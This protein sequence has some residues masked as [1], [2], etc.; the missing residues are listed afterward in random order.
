MD[1]R[2]HGVFDSR[3]DSPM[4][5]LFPNKQTNKLSLT[6]WLTLL[7]DS[8]THFVHCPLSPHTLPP[9]TPSPRSTA[10]RPPSSRSAPQTPLPIPTAIVPPITPH[11]R[12][13]K[14]PSG[15]RSSRITCSNGE[16]R[17]LK[18]SPGSKS[19][20]PDG[21]TVTL[22]SVSYTEICEADSR[23]NPL[24]SSEPPH[25]RARRSP[26]ESRSGTRATSLRGSF[27]PPLR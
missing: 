23:Q 3:I 9:F 1:S 25:R 27:A 7:T 2:I 26:A 15:L 10:P 8:L 20:A 16:I 18:N 6:H 21:S 24:R 13:A 4:H 17:Y 5:S 22:L 19:A 14:L 11:K 12:T